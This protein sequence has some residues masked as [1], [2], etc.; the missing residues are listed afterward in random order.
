MNSCSCIKQSQTKPGISLCSLVGLS[1]PG[2]GHALVIC[3]HTDT[4]LLT[5]FLFLPILYL[6][7]KYMV[8][9]VWHVVQK[10]SKNI[11]PFEDGNNLYC[12]ILSH[13]Q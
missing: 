5:P 11:F 10:E 12:E 1:L 8:Y 6:L 9:I 13:I 3:F 7:W 4:K 2:S